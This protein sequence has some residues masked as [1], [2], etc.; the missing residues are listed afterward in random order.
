MPILS[1]IALAQLPM[2]FFEPFEEKAVEFYG[3]SLKK[4]AEHRGGLTPFEAYKLLCTPHSRYVVGRYDGKGFVG[5]NMH[6]GVENNVDAEALLVSAVFVD[7]QQQV[8]DITSSS[9]RVDIPEGSDQF[10]MSDAIVGTPEAIPEMRF[11]IIGET[12]EHILQQKYGAQMLSGG[13]HCH[14]RDVPMFYIP[15][16]KDRHDH[17]TPYTKPE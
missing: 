17:G 13:Y 7:L 8:T 9:L 11:V 6:S 3:R 14:W 4:I 1:G 2:R 5:F 16:K 15:L 10:P 12:G